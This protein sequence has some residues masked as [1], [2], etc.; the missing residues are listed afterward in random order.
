MSKPRV[1]WKDSVNG[2][3]IVRRDREDFVIESMFN[4]EMGGESW[5]PCGLLNV[6]PASDC[7]SNLPFGTMLLILEKL[8]R[9]RR[10]RKVSR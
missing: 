5:R 3:R 6:D 2:Y 8:S 4:D 7:M 10:R 9:R 1:I